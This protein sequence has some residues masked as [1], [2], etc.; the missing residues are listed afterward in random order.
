MEIISKKIV[1]NSLWMMLE[2]F[3]G[4]FGVIFVNSYM[5][6]YVGAENF[7][8]IIFAAS[9]FLFVQSIA[10]FG[11]QNVYFKRMSENKVSGLK[12]AIANL[13]FRRLVFAISSIIALIYFYFFTDAV[14]FIFGLASC[15]VSY[16]SINDIL[17][18]YNN[19]QLK[20]IIN[21]ITNIIGLVVALIL[22]YILVYYECNIYYMTIP[23][24]LIVVIPYYLRWLLAK[25]QLIITGGFI[26]KNN[27]RYNIYLWNTGGALLLSSL[28]IVIYNQI[29]N[30]FLAKFSSFSELGIYN[31][32]MTL[33]GAWAFVNVA[34]ISSI[35]SKIYAEKSKD[36]SEYFIVLTHYVIIFNSLM[37]GGIL[38]FLGPW[39]IKTLYGSGYVEAG[40]I[41][42]FIVF[43]TALSN[44]GVINYRYM[45]K[46][47]AY[48]YLSIKMLFVSLLSIP[49]SFF[50][51]KEYG[52]WGAVYCFIL[53][54][55][56]SLTL[57]NYI[58]NKGEIFKLH[59]KLLN[60]FY[61]VSKIK[62]MK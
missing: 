22:R 41:L 8:K 61:L 45:M 7:G 59:L 18:I 58:F 62:A 10:W 42:V 55:C 53:V 37:V 39:L 34:I 57:A 26:A 9:I 46:L 25:K 12:L 11:S 54:E 27:R 20:S 60:P 52:V 13:N 17:S 19:S 2:K 44:M 36:N 30:I 5:A 1:S 14:V 49:C 32:A 6:K 29:S 3:I 24:V 23:I 51:I 16:Y 28:S 33:G 43:A 35:F 50:L 15:I 40:Q 31:V 21:A 47:G 56:I 48:K 38:Y 4:I